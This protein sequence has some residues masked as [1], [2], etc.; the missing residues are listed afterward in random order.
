MLNY[1]CVCYMLHI[2]VLINKKKLQIL[3]KKVRGNIEKIENT[4]LEDYFMLVINEV[5]S[6]E[7]QK[8][9]YYKN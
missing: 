9:A 5:S 3:S 8:Y 6:Y 4:I 7:N 2:Y 1:A